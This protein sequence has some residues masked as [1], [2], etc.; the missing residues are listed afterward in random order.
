MIIPYG[1]HHIDQKDIKNVTTSLN[2]NFITQGPLIKKFE[3]N[4]CKIVKVKYAVAVN[5]CSAGL[6]LAVKCLEKIKKKNEIITSPVSFVS[7]SNAALLNNYKLKFIDIDQFN[8]NINLKALSNFLKNK[9]VR[10]V[11]PVHLAGNAN[12]SKEIFKLCKKTNTPIIEDAAHSFGAKYPNGKMVG[13]CCYANMTVF[14]F[15][16]VK[17]ITTGEGGVIT[18]NSKK[19]YKKLLLLRSHGIEKNSSLWKNKKLG[20]S[21]QKKNQWYYEVQE[22]GYN[23]RITDFQCALGLSQL[24]KLNKILIKRKK[25]ANFYDKNFKNINNIFIPQFQQR[26]NSSNHLYIL[27]INF[28]NLKI[29]RNF[30]MNFLMKKKIITQVHYIPIP[31]HPLYKKLGYNIKHLNNTKKYYETAISIPIYYNLSKNTQKKIINSIKYLIK[32]FKK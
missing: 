32:K 28:K 14:S 19:I 9:N 25:I 8:L 26:N 13:S 31:L 30:F 29:N 16:P 7:T 6:H 15:H 27:N 2:N 24:Q 18:T 22:L 4:I 20:Y 3:K 5:S 21:N 1:I 17:T 23:Y 12:N 10:A 11:I